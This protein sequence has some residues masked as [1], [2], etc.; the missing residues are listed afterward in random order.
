MNWLILLHKRILKKPGFLIL[1]CCIPL[2]VLGLNMVS[3]QD[4]GMLRVI[5]CHGEGEDVL[6]DSIKE[7]LREHDNLIAFTEVTTEDAAVKIVQSGEADV[8]WIFPENCKESLRQF[9]QGNSDGAAFIKVIEREDNVALRLSREI[10]FGRIYPT[11]SYEVYE[12]YV[13][14]E[15]LSGEALSDDYLMEKYRETEVEGNL[16]QFTY[17]DGSDGDTDTSYLLFPV[18][19]LLSLVIVLCSLSL[20]IYYMQDEQEGVFLWKFRKNRFPDGVIYQIPGMLDAGIMVMVSLFIAGLAAEWWIEILLMAMYLVMVVLFTD[21]VRRLCKKPVILGALIPVI[22]LVLFALSPIFMGAIDAGAIQFL[23]PPYYY[24]NAVHN[25]S[26]RLGMLVYIVAV[27]MLDYGI[28]K[29]V[30]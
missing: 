29:I 28:F 3:T 12:Q 10:L 25:T 17:L 11:I 16:F 15:L 21:V 19:G 24:L 30:K 22:I 4:S 13:R 8:A 7:K 18:R 6:Y 14:G 5:L 9:L 27:G 20:G 2:L 1:L 26:Y 23:L